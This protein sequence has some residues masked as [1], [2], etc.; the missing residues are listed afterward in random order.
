M[1][2]ARRN[3]VV[4]I[5]ACVWLLSCGGGGAALIESPPPEF[6]SVTITPDSVSVSVGGVILLTATPRDQNGTAISG[7]GAPSWTVEDTAIAVATGSSISGKTI[8][9]TRVFASMTEGGVTRGDTARVVVTAAPAGSPAHPVNT[10]GTSFSPGTVSVAVG[11]SVTWLFLGATHNVTFVPGGPIPPGGDIADQASGQVVSRIFPV[12][13]TY[14]YECTRHANM[15]GQV[16]VQSGQP[17]V[18]TSVALAPGAASLLAGGTIQLTADPLD[19][20]GVPIGGLVPATFATSAAA[21]ATVSSSGTVTAA[22]PG[23]ATITASITSAAVTRTATAIITVNTPAA[24]ATVTTPNLTFAPSTVT[25]Q[26]GQTVTWDFSGAVHNVTFFTAVPPGFNI[27]DQPIGSV[28]PRTFPTAG[29]Y[30]YECTRHANMAGAVIVQ[31]GQAQVYTSVSIAPVTTNLVVGGTVSLTATPLDQSGVPM[32]GLPAASFTSGSAA[33]ATVSSTGVVTATGAGTADITATIVSGATTHSATGTVLVTAAPPGGVTVST[34][35]TN[36]FSPGTVAI[37]AGG[38]V[39][40]QFGNGTHNVTWNAGSPQ[41]PG[42][43]IPDQSAG[44]QSRAFPTAGNYTYQCTRH[45]GMTGTVT[46]S[47]GG[48][49]PVFTTLAVQPLSPSVA[50]GSTVQLIATPLDQNGT[51]MAGLPAATFTSSD[52]TVAIVTTAGL[53]SGVSQGSATITA[54][55]TANGVTHTGVSVV[56]VGTAPGTI[57]TTPG[58]SFNPDDIRIPPGTTVTWQISGAS[59]N[60]TFETIAPPGG[61]IGTTAPG[62]SVSRTFTQLGEYKYF[63]SI[64]GFDAKVRV[65]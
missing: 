29:V 41:P 18:F 48:G 40:W 12:P 35:N 45:N 10:P 5:A 9:S 32:T 44:A 23:T 11:D 7:L 19:Q 61:N 34:T 65:E 4:V 47:G 62:N 8:G 24:G 21:V 59:H 38:T 36:T 2:L 26:A 33:I 60:I 1:R 42:G 6:T 50:V 31:S 30:T 25:I 49:P 39:T 17:Q 3:A 27:P 15:T 51:I 63:C 64:H 37:T 54:S 43:S 56:S 53:V 16:I 28:I 57:V 22:G 14:Q 52:A 58:L 20:N 13:G 46:V 55:L